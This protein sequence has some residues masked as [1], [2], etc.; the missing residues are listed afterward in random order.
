MFSVEPAKRQLAPIADVPLTKEEVARR[1]R[2]RQMLIAALIVALSIAAFIG[3]RLQHRAAIASVVA[4]AE[5]SG[6]LADIDAALA[7]LD[8]EDAPGDVAVRARL[9]AT[10]VLAGAGASA[11]SGS[12]HAARAA[13]HLAAHDASGEG[14]S[15]HRIA[16]TYL[17]LSLG[18]PESAAEEA[19]LLVAGRGPRAAEAAHARALAALAIGNL[20]A[21]RAAAESA[22]DEL[23][24]SP[25]HAAL[26]LEIASRA[27]IAAPVVGAEDATVLRIARA[28]VHL[29]T[30]TDLDG[31]ETEASAVLAASDATPAERAWAE[32]VRGLVASEQG[33]TLEAIGALT[34]AAALPP[35]GDELF[36]IELAEGWLSLG[37]VAECDQA[38][39]AMHT[40]VS[41]DASRRDLILS[42]RALVRGDLA[43][44]ERSLALVAARPRRD[45]VE[46]QLAIARGEWDRAR[47]LLDRAIATPETELTAR[48]ELSSMLVVT[49]HA[50]E[51]LEPIQALLDAHP[52]SPR[53]AAAA[54]R[55]YAAM[56]DRGRALSVLDAALV[57]HPS[58]PRLLLEKARV[59]ARAAEWE[60]AFAALNRA[61]ESSPRDPVI[62]LERG[63]AARAVGRLDEARSA[64]ATSLT[65]SPGQARALVALLGADL[66]AHA[67]DEARATEAALGGL[68]LDR[69]DVDALRARYFVEALAG[70]RGVP[71]IEAAVARAPDDVALRAALARLYFQAERWEDAADTFYAVAQRSETERP[72]ALGL[73]AVA[74]ARARRAPTVEAVL[75]QLRTMQV[76]A[77]LPSAVEALMSVAQGWLEWHEEAF[78]RAGIFARQALDRDPGNTHAN[79]LLAVL[80]SAGRRDP[81]EHARVAIADVLEARGMVGL[82]SSGDAAPDAERCGFMRLYL[83]G[84]PEGRL[85]A[86]TRTRVSACPAEAP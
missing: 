80:D 44:A 12:T 64:L 39:E 7:A 85:A 57:L 30:S 51:A 6:R 33:D 27:G 19:S 72:M 8:G 4:T 69:P 21:A 60:P 62:Q 3:Y 50:S 63:L 48:I 36:Q 14:A 76:V 71:A 35:P 32:L 46:A 59:H 28:R 66:D 16:A 38:L 70:A 20:D 86:D 5:S 67:I 49:S 68:G 23:T 2:N 11:T 65:L 29:E 54:G 17:A 81:S 42:R 47:T 22:R 26:V 61:A 56:G 9:H 73:R 75:D 77:R 45:L 10:A 37:M 78:G 82:L 13:E 74:L 40:T 1:K 83:E 25:R 43:E 34:R 84:A 58:E 18:D 79:L 31:A 15:D 24:G 41:T 55:A 52:T 53:L